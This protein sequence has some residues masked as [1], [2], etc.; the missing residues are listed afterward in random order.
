MGMRCSQPQGLSSEA[1]EFLSQ[2]AI[3]LNQCTCCQR[4]DGYKKEVID[5]C[6]MYDDVDLYRYT[7]VDGTMADEFV[8]YEVWSSGPMIWFGLRWQGA[9]FVWHSDELTE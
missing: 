5:T 8:Q 4:H 9:E 2:N 1:M 6:G 3:K 7:L